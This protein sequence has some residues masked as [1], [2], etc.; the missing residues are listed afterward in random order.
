MWGSILAYTVFQKLKGVDLGV[1][2]G[3]IG[4]FIVA[5]VLETLLVAQSHAS[6]GVTKNN[7]NKDKVFRFALASYVTRVAT[8]VAFLSTII[9]NVEN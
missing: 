9:T 4:P 6:F 2:L 8:V 1:T 3:E 7:D 5:A